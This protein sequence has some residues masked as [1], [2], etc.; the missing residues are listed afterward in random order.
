MFIKWRGE[1]NSKRS[2]PLTPE[3][4]EE[5][6][7]ALVVHPAATTAPCQNCGAKAW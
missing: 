5:I 2:R 1:G 7:P 3:E 4:V 6:R